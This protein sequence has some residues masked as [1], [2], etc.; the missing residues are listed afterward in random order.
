MVAPWKKS[1]DKSKQHIIKQ[2]HNFANKGPSSQSYGFSTGHVWMRG[3]DHKE[4][5]VPKNLWFWTVVLEKTLESPLDCKEIQ[6]VNPKGNKSGILI[7]RTDVEAETPI[8]W[9]PDVKNWLIDKTLMLGRIEGRKKRGWQR[10][11]LLDCIMDLMHMS[12]CKLWE[13]VMDR[14]AWHAAV[15]GVTE[16]DTTEW[17]NWTELKWHSSYLF[18]RDLYCKTSCLIFD[19]YLISPII[20]FPNTIN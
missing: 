14:E 19:K 11:R 16:S 17:L 5:W 4:N 10:M 9:P 12:L 15:H 20:C 8:L 1:Y 3:L 7:G 6:P 2:R 18:Q 13:L